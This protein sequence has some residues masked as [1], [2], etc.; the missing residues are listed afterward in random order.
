MELQQEAG[1]HPLEGIQHATSNGAK[2]LGLTSTG[3]VRPGFAA[4]LAIVDGNPLHNMKVLYGT[5]VD[6]EEGGK[7]V[8]RGGVRYT[9]KGG[10][11]FD[12]PALLAEVREMVRQAN[13]QS[14]QAQRAVGSRAP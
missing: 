1:F 5:G 10:V 13:E 4:D 7:V 6:V 2:L 12:A 3:V 14:A 9:I 11:V 8:H